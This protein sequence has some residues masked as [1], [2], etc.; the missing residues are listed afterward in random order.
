LFQN[1]FFFNESINFSEAIQYKS[2]SLTG[3]GAA[4]LSQS[5]K[6]RFASGTNSLPKSGLEMHAFH[7]RLEKFFFVFSSLI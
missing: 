6:D 4:Q 7:A 2:Y 5:V 1:F 3:A